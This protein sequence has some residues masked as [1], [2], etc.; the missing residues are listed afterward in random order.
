MK[1]L[2]LAKECGVEVDEF[3]LQTSLRHNVDLRTAAYV[4]AVARVGTVTKMRGMYA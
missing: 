4:V 1:F 3:T 2:L